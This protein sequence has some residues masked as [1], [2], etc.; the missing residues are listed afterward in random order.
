MKLPFVFLLTLMSCA[1]SVAQPPRGPHPPPRIEA[2][3]GVLPEKA[4]Q[5]AILGALEA[6]EADDFANF[7]LLGTD[8][9]K[10]GLKKEW[11]DSMVKESAPRLQNGYN[12]VYFGDIKREDYTVYMWKLVFADKGDDW[13]GEISWKNSKMDGFKIH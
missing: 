9:F 7:A 3:P 6:I 5:E 1:V 2:A 4:V 8:N 10:A 13:L 12:I 11:F